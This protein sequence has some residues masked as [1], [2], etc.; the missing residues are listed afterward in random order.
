MGEVTT[1]RRYPKM[2]ERKM[3]SRVGGGRPTCSSS[4]ARLYAPTTSKSVSNILL[5]AEG[6]ELFSIRGG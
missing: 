2:V 5:L 3:S 6:P 1:E 4:K